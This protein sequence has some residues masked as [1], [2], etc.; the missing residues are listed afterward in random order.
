MYTRKIADAEPFTCAGIEFGMVLPRDLTDSSEVVLER[1]TSGQ[2]TP[3]DSHGTFDQIFII[4]EGRGLLSIGYEEQQV[5]AHTVAFI[6]RNTPHAI[7]CLTEEDLV[8]LYINVWGQGVPAAEQEWKRVYLQIH[9]R[10]TLEAEAE[11]G[12]AKNPNQTPRVQ[13]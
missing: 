1:L 11:E 3:V 10:R 8:Y 12:G 5:G 6:P 9:C 4:L 13:A 7:K 2:A